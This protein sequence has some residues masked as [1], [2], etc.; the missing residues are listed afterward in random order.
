MDDINNNSGEAKLNKNTMLQVIWLLYWGSATIGMSK[1]ITRP[2]RRI[3]SSHNSG[4]S[5]VDFWGVLIFFICLLGLISSVYL[6]K[7]V[8]W[9]RIAVG[10]LAM[11]QLPYLFL[12][13]AAFPA[14][15]S[16]LIWIFAAFCLL[17]VKVLLFPKNNESKADVD[18]SDD[19]VVLASRVDRLWASLLDGITIVPV[20]IP[21]VYFTGGFSTI[22]AGGKLSLAYTLLIA[23]IAVITFLIIHGKFIATDG[24]TLGK[25]AL[26]IKIVT[27]DGQ[28]AKIPALMKR[29][30][31]YFFAPLVPV[32][33]QILNMVNIVFIFSESK[34][35]LH[36]RIGGTI[37]VKS[38]NKVG[39]NF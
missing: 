22:L 27:V 19:R 16:W 34:R 32:F 14:N 7:G 37:V 33:G 8:K 29:Y 30:A 1:A 9:A 21:L 11:L 15:M 13:A 26:N 38:T 17:S 18:N 24:Q 20:T 6:F 10:L 3:F 31:F 35:C 39:D 23:I 36:D 12:F 28:Q 5:L 25:K 2:L 4:F